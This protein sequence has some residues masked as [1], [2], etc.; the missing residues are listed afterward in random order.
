MQF[1]TN[2]VLASIIGFFQY[3]YCGALIPSYD[4]THSIKEPRINICL[5]HGPG[6]EQHLILWA[7]GYFSQVILIWIAFALLSRTKSSADFISDTLNI[8]K[9]KRGGRLTSF[10]IYDLVCFTFV[11][12]SGS[13]LYYFYYYDQENPLKYI[14]IIGSL[15][16]FLQISYGMLSFPFSV[17]MIGI[18]VRMFTNAVPTSYDQE[19]NCVPMISNLKITYKE[20]PLNED[21]DPIDIEDALKE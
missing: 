10:M 2:G 8:E 6:V 13:L 19:G 1:F 20:I 3:Y 12:S 17:F 11:L 7:I 5:T 16:N 4:L 18:F 14:Y 9:Q 15:I 21:E